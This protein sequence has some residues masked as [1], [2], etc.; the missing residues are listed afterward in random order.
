M[1]SR[2]LRFGSSGDDVTRLQQ[3]LAQDPSIY[4]EGKVSGYFGS[5]TERAVE[6]FQ[7]KYGVVSSGTAKTTGYGLVGQKT[8]AKLAE[9][10][11]EQQIAQPQEKT[12]VPSA[13]VQQLKAKIQELQQQ[14]LQL[15]QQLLQS[16]KSKAG[17]S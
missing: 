8:R 6:R 16:L 7:L 12:P 1:F 9:I 11:G 15:L 13:T 10:F 14:L 17:G 3:L 5:L 4:P 2:N